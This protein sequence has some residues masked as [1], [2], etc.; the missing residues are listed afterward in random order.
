MAR[1]LPRFYSQTSLLDRAIDSPTLRTCKHDD[2]F[3]AARKGDHWKFPHETV[4]RNLKAKARIECIKAR[5]LG[6]NTLVLSV[7][8]SDRASIGMAARGSKNSSG[9]ALLRYGALLH[10]LRADVDKIERPPL[11]VGNL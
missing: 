6:L 1:I 11:R 9:F 4:N 10:L 8:C 3:G 5:A 2:S 7:R